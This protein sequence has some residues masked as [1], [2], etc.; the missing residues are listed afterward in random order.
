MS[1]R[2]D[3]GKVSTH[4]ALLFDRRHGVREYLGDHVPALL[5]KQWS[6]TGSKQL[7]A[8]AELLPVV[9]AKRTWARRLEGRKILVFIDNEGV[10]AWCVRTPLDTEPMQWA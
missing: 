10:N 9:V 2:E 1:R 4:G 7:I 6:A 3:E 8:Q 5:A